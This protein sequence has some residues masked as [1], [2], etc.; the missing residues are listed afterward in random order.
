[1]KGDIAEEIVHVRG[2]PQKVIIFLHGYI[3]NCE[4]LNHRI[5]AFADSFDNTAFHIPES[6][7]LCE[8]HENK[9]QWFSMHRFDPDDARKFVPTMEEC[10][11]IYDRMGQ[12]LAEAYSYLDEYIEERLNMYG[13]EA[14]DLYLCGFSQ[15]AMLA[16]YYALRHE[17]T[18]GG[19]I[20]FSGI[21]TPHTYLLKHHK[22]SPD[23]LLIHG[24]ADNLVRFEA[25]NFTRNLLEQMGCNV[26]T[27][28]VEEGRHMVTEDGLAQALRYISRHQLKQKAV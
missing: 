2:M 26:S 3:D 8:I 20:S 27:Y 14:K 22:S 12:G 7:L 11:A 9:R 13:L 28:V 18:I 16:L 5:E 23:V 6:P 1:M 17:E 10:V 25:L 15:G 21:L 24:N 4:C 19:C